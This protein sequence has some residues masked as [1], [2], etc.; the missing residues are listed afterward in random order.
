MGGADAVVAALAEA[1]AADAGAVGEAVAAVEEAGI[2]TAAI[3][4]VAEA[5]TVAGRR[6]IPLPNLR[7]EAGSSPRRAPRFLLQACVASPH[8]RQD[9]YSCVLLSIQ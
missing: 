5:E 2:V 4:A 6:A 1:V 7:L 8:P 3:G 9:R